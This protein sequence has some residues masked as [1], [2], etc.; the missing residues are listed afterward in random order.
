MFSV[1]DLYDLS[2]VY[3]AIREFPE[4][5]LNA[6]VLKKVI[7]VIEK[8]DTCHDFNQIRAALSGI[9]HL[10]KNVFYFVDHNNV[11]TYF[12][13]FLKDELVYEVLLTATK[14]LLSLIESNNMQETVELTDC[15]HNLPVDISENK[16]KIPKK[17]WRCEAMAFRKK[18]DRD[19]LAAEERKI[20]LRKF[21]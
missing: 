17:F 12:P 21:K 13:D 15:L 16:M 1:Y 9:A 8:R 14:Y 6:D 4:Y 11:Y 5:G 20:K 19:F 18:Y 10:D 3:K 7:E 2:A